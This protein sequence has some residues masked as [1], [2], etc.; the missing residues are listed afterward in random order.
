[1]ATGKVKG[2]FAGCRTKW[3]GLM[4]GI[5]CGI[6]AVLHCRYTCS[7]Y[8]CY[9]YIEEFELVTNRTSRPRLDQDSGPLGG[10]EMAAPQHTAPCYPKR[11]RRAIP[12]AEASAH[13]V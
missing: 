11:G 12:Q 10:E 7:C 13:L 9:R 5:A 8:T 1:M 6:V 2:D 3:F 4:C